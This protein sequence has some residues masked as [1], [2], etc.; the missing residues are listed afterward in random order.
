[1]SPRRTSS[2]FSLCPGGTCDNSP[3]FQCWV[4]ATVAE[5]VPNGRLKPR[6]TA[7][8]SLRDL[9]IFEPISNVEI[10]T[11]GYYQASLRDED[12]I[13]ATLDRNVRAPARA[14]K[15]A[16]DLIACTTALALAL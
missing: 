15:C 9:G 3:T 13:P 4:N 14:P 5:L 11:L 2:V 16:R 7:Q 12:Q 8:P 10:E 6:R 1:M